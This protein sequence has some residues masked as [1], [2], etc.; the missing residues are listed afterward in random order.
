MLKKTLR[1]HLLGMKHVL[2][3]MSFAFA[4]YYYLLQP[5]FFLFGP[6][7]VLIVWPSFL[8]LVLAHSTHKGPSNPSMSVFTEKPCR[9][10]SSIPPADVLVTIPW[11]FSPIHVLPSVLYCTILLPTA[12]QANSRQALTGEGCEFSSTLGKSIRRQYGTMEL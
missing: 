3:F 12:G 7:S 2:S 10:S 9:S 6:L 1:M 8:F 4:A 11:S 5:S